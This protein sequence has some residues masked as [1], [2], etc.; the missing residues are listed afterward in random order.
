MPA[1]TT[2][3][4]RPV[5]TAA[6]T[7]KATPFAA[8]L[9]MKLS[10]LRDGG[11]IIVDGQLNKSVSAKIRMD[12]GINSPTRGQF[13]ASTKNFLKGGTAERAMTKNE[14]EDLSQ[15][16]TKHMANTPGRQPE[17]VELNKRIKEA[18]A[19]FGPAKVN[20]AKIPTSVVGPNANASVEGSMWVDRMPG[21]GP[22]SNTVHVSAKLQGNGFDDSAP[23]YGVKKIEVYEKG[24]NKLVATINNPKE[25]DAGRIGRGT[26]YHEFALS[27]PG[28]KVDLTKQYSV[29][30]T[31]TIN[32]SAPK[33]VRSEFMNV[34]QVF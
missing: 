21:P 24:T 13:F 23:N 12:G 11:S 4:V 14:L 1:I 22:K 19:K 15:A 2:S 31:T 26:H 27:I 6:V 10:K 16:I 9:P 3:T 18:L 5:A 25:T 33:Q 29:V 30:F 28:S 7:S 20:V 8:F 17:Y 34:G 32:G